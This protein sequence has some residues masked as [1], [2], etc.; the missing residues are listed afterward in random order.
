MILKFDETVGIILDELERLGIDDR[1]M[2]VLCSDN[3]HEVYALQ[4]GR[5]SGR[6]D[7]SEMVRRLITSA[8]SFTLRRAGM[9]LT[10]TTAWLA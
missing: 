10:G 5:T 1:T 4:E 2:V 3:G 9:Y 8:R 7:G 6:T